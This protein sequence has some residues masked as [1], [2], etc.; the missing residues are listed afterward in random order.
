MTANAITEDSFEV[1]GTTAVL[2]VTSPLAAV[3]ARRLAEHVLADV[4][5]ACSRFRPDSELTR[6]NE[7][8]GEPMMISATFA[9]LLSAALRAARLTGGD[10][11][12]T[13]GQALAGL[14]YDRDFAELRAG[15]ATPLRLAG[16][17]G[18]VPGWRR[19]RL[20]NGARRVRLEH[21]AQLD[22]GATA[23]AWAADTCAEQIARRTGCGVLVSL[24]GD[25]AVAGTPPPEGWQIRVADDHAAPPDAPGQTV[26]ITSGGLATSSTTVRAWTV[27][28]RPVHHIIDPATGEPASSCWRTVSVAAGTCTDANTASTA[29]IIRSAAAPAWLRDMGL[30][31]RL[32]RHDGTVETT[33]GWPGDEPG[34]G[35]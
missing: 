23:K 1:W 14:G 32:V 22:L 25:V 27:A 31:A 24:G 33:A 28:G 7:A 8:G 19:V 34:G 9:D 11:D 29:A 18:A 13:C 35:A 26:T 17:A 4:D 12:P 16:P 20:D 5:L 2:L 15:G 6:L 3:P 30:P 10:V 21:G